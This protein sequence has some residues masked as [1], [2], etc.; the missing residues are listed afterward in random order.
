MNN[1][2]KPYCKDVKLSLP[3]DDVKLACQTVFTAILAL[4]TI[5]LVW[6]L[7]SSPN[8]FTLVK[9]VYNFNTFFFPVFLVIWVLL[10][11]TLSKPMRWG[12]GFTLVIIFSLALFA[13]RVYA[14]YIEPHRL[15]VVEQIIKT[16]KLAAPLKIVHLTDIQSAEVGA[17]EE[18]AIQLAIEQKPDLVLFTGDLL[19][20][21][22]DKQ[23]DNE[24]EKISVLLEQIDAPLGVYGVVGNVDGW[25]EEWRLSKLRGMT[26]LNGK[27]V[28]LDW[29]E[30][31]I[32]LYGVSFQG[33]MRG[34]L[35]AIRPWF[36]SIPDDEYSIVIG[37]YP[38]YILDHSDL[39]IDLCLAGHIH[40]GQI[41]IPGF[42]PIVTF[43]AVP[44]WMSRG[45]HEY[46]N[47]RINVS[48]GV[49]C[50]RAAGVPKIRVFCPPEF[51]VFEISGEND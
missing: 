12:R 8:F 26:I 49:G 41:V 17:Y 4:N 18:R 29:H 1:Q 7:S 5:V 16:E 44:R 43:S 20:P 19:Q 13:V 23:I 15:Q 34:H 31:A 14:T 3:S 48:A 45:F 42:G 37:H 22:I 11:A 10:S 9:Y 32:H 35:A 38:D 39:P 2:I 6:L 21:I 25:M 24:I 46:G 28:K 36:E 40:G 47:T 27:G 30:K 51:S 33:S 50:E